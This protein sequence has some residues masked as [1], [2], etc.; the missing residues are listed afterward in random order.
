VFSAYLSIIVHML[1]IQAKVISIEKTTT[2]TTTS[3]GTISTTL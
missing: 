2:T 3:T 1:Q